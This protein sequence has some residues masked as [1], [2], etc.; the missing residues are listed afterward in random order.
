MHLRCIYSET[1]Y[2]LAV[3]PHNPSRIEFIRDAI[4]LTYCLLH[5]RCETHKQP[6]PSV[7]N[8]WR[9][10]L[11]RWVANAEN[12]LVL[13]HEEDNGYLSFTTLVAPTP[14]AAVQPAEATSEPNSDI[15]GAEEALEDQITRPDWL[16]APGDDPDN[17]DT[18]VGRPSWLDDESASGQNLDER[19]WWELTNAELLELFPPG[20]VV[21]PSI[22]GF[23]ERLRVEAM[24]EAARSREDNLSPVYHDPEG[25]ETSESS[26]LELGST[27]S[28]SIVP[29]I[30]EGAIEYESDWEQG[31][32][33]QGGGE[34]GGGEQGGGEQGSGE[35]QPDLSAWPVYFDR[36]EERFVP[37]IDNLGWIFVRGFIVGIYRVDPKGNRQMVYLTPLRASTIDIPRNEDFPDIDS[38][39]SSS[40]S[41]TT[42]TSGPSSSPS[43]P[44]YRFVRNK[45][46]PGIQGTLENQDFIYGTWHQEGALIYKRVWHNPRW[47]GRPLNGG[48]GDGVECP[49]SQ[50]GTCDLKPK[51]KGVNP[52]L[53]KPGSRVRPQDTAEPTSLSLQMVRKQHRRPNPVRDAL[54]CG[55][56]CSSFA[57]CGADACRCVAKPGAQNAGQLLWLGVCSGWNGALQAISAAASGGGGGGKRKRRKRGLFMKRELDGFSDVTATVCPCNA[58]YVSISCCGV[59]NGL[60]WE[61]PEMKLGVLTFEDNELR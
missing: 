41:T 4:L 27:S 31:G 19:D 10:I 22:E 50:Q 18:E 59:E 23:V 13:A 11:P 46:L 42:Q 60:V 55:K 16:D 43:P 3:T 56:S 49:A 53:P 35:I 6:S 8:Q 34:Q 12:G 33:E 51:Y 30:G 29:L 2:R 52:N 7:S 1:G 15:E 21:P 61:G 24:V 14:V 37:A 58:S 26:S 9:N 57:G 48:G 28:D 39:S 25:E 20:S 5:C 32:G 40:S 47:K 38:T 36:S 44:P 17:D 54:K 45:K